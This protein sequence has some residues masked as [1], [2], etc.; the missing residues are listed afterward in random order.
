[1]SGFCVPEITSRRL[2]IQLTFLLCVFVISAGFSYQFYYHVKKWKYRETIIGYYRKY[3]HQEP[4]EIPLRH[5][6]QLAV[7]RWG[8]KR[9]E[10]VF[11]IGEK[12]PQKS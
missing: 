4:Q 5:L 2:K 3:T 1:M 6:T 7:N 12:A 8:L 10:K 11:F 9:V